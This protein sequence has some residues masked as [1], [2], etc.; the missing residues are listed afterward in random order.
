MVSEWVDY[1]GYRFVAPFLCMCC[2]VETDVRQWAF[3]RT[4]AKCDTGICQPW[5]MDYELK[6]AHENPPWKRPFGT[7]RA[8]A[9]AAFVSHVHVV[10]GAGS[11]QAA[12]PEEAA[13]PV[14]DTQEKR[15]G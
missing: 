1:E 13:H 2:G 8:A 3:G 5:N 7:P 9:I 11:V 14:A 6:Y 12:G 15:R 10:R 4:C